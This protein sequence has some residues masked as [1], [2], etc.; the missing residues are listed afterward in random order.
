MQTN[1][2]KV[3][4]F[5]S[6]GHMAPDPLSGS[7]TLTDSPTLDHSQITVQQIRSADRHKRCLARD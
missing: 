3:L 4:I 5:R 6:R 2:L 7:L 1:D